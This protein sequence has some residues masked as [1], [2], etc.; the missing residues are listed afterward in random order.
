M[1]S[2]VITIAHRLLT[3]ADSDRVLVMKEGK[4]VEFDTV[5]RLMEMEG[6][7]FRRMMEIAKGGSEGRQEETEQQM[8]A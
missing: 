3:I 5:P 6:G 1:L 4:A 8:V 2:T 7:V